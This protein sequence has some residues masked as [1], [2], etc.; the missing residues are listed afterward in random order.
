MIEST[1]NPQIKR[2]VK[3]MNKPNDQFVVQ[4][5]NLVV[6][7]IKSN[8][9]VKLYYLENEK[10]IEG[11]FESEII[12]KRVAKKISGVE[13]GNFIFGICNFHTPIIDLDKP[14]IVL[15][16]IQDPGNL[17]NIIRTLAAFKSSNLILINC[18]NQFNQKV[19]RSAMGGHFHLNILVYQDSSEVFELLYKNNY[20]SIG[21][22]LDGEVIKKTPTDSKIAFWFG[23][24]GN[25][26]LPETQAKM[27]KNILIPISNVESLNVGTT[28]AIVTYLINQE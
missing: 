19:L 26:L 24:E 3:L 11:Q 13:N 25:G 15:E 10:I 12:S 22:S 6:E 8:N 21:L 28:V 20:K 7:A 9:L 16:K 18:V 5:Y 27:D 2:L 17:G 23:N 1:E 14:I 4:G